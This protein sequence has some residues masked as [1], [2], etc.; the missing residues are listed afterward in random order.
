MTYLK[1]EERHAAILDAAAKVILSEGLFAATVRRI[2]KEAGAA[3]G[4][5]HHHFDSIKSLRAQ[6]FL[7]LTRKSQNSFEIS[8]KNCTAIER[9]HHVLGYPI[10]DEG[11]RE[12]ERWN[13]VMLESSRDNTMREAYYIA[14]AEWH[15]ATSR[16]ITDG[17]ASNEFR[18]GGNSADDIAW[19]LIGLVCGLDGLLPFENSTLTEMEV[20]RHLNNA[21]ALELL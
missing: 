14:I 2:A 16:I 4:Q 5:I 15:E 7:H 3:I 6:A 13:E 18:P 11:V 21:I 17:R 9:I 1:H 12:T 10:N 8:N 20:I 19:R